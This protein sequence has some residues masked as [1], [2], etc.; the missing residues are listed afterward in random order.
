MSCLSFSIFITRAGRVKPWPD[1]VWYTSRAGRVKERLDPSLILLVFF[2]TLLRG[3]RVNSK[4]SW[5]GQLA[6]L[7]SLA[8]GYT[9]P[10]TNTTFTTSTTHHC[11]RRIWLL[12][13]LPN[14][15]QNITSLLYF[16]GSKV[17]ID[18]ANWS[19]PVEYYY[20]KCIWKEHMA[21]V[22]QYTNMHRVI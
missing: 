9:I 21:C 10:Y 1:S 18:V 17:S 20:K 2:W 8:I 3:V 19:V 16:S 7:T 12:A 22:L 11:R 15:Q 4:S 14:G 6:C 5:R 13:L